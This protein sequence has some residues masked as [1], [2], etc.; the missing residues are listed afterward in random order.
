LRAN[1]RGNYALILALSPL[2]LASQNQRFEIEV[3]ESWKAKQQRRGKWK[4]V[5]QELRVEH[6]NGKKLVLKG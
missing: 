3:G 5:V 1:L 4:K 6:Q 2:K